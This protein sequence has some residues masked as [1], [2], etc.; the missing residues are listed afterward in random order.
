MIMS[1]H[2]QS[3]TEFGLPLKLDRFIFFFSP[4]TNQIRFIQYKK[5]VDRNGCVAECCYRLGA[6]VE[7]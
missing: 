4:H 1:Q 6:V 7:N 5:K 3:M 2:W